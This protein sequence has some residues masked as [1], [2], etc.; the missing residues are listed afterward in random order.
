[1]GCPPAEFVPPISKPATFPFNVS[2]ALTF[3]DKEIGEL[4]NLKDVTEPVKFFLVV[5]QYPI[6]TTSSSACKS[7]ASLILNNV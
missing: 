4:S 7:S 1:V 5:V 3:E 2:R 6:T